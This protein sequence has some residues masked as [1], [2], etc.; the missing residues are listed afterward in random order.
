VPVC[1]LSDRAP[2]VVIVDKSDGRAR[3]SSTH[4]AGPHLVRLVQAG[5]II[6]A[7]LWG[8]GT[9]LGI[10]AILIQRQNTPEELAG[11]PARRR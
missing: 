10:Y 6:A 2:P 9:T 11:F 8:G 7:V 5:H 4:A 1:Q 3:Y